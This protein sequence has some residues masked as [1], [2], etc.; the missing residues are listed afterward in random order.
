MPSIYLAG[1]IRKHDWRGRLV[2]SP[3]MRDLSNPW[4]NVPCLG[5]LKGFEYAGPFY[6]ECRHGCGP[7]GHNVSGCWE[8]GSD[9]DL[10]YRNCRTAIEACDVFFAWL[11][12]LRAHGTLWEIGF[13][14]AL[15]KPI[16]IGRS[17]SMP[18]PNEV[19]LPLMAA[20]RLVVSEH[21]EAALEMLQPELRAAC[22]A[23]EKGEAAARAAAE[24]QRLCG[25][26]IEQQLLTWLLP[27][28]SYGEGAFRRNGHV[29][30]VQHRVVGERTY[31]L[32]IALVSPWSRVAVECDGHAFHERTKEQAASDRSRDRDLTLRGWSVMRF[33]GSEIHSAPDRCALQVVAL[34]DASSSAPLEGAEH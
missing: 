6:Y 15:G 13:A 10:V 31:R 30:T 8:E 32:D 11:D 17:S 25:S 33:T 27:L 19:W 22:V 7:G 23:R 5:V 21:P 3:G 9:Q 4:E 12:D 26:P 29:L 28:F 34:I 20:R 2:V 14:S 18:K 1:R 16:Y 24:L